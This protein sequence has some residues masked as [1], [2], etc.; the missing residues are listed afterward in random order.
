MNIY[1]KW[2]YPKPVMDMR[3]AIASGQYLEIGDPSFYWPLMWPSKRGLDVNLNILCAGCGSNQAAYYA[4]QHPTWNVV[5]IDVSGSSLAH[6]Q[7]L[8][9]KHGLSNLELIEMDLSRIGELEK[10]FDFITCTGVLHH[11]DAPDEGLR[12]LAGALHPDGVMNLMVYGKSLRMGI[13]P[14]QEAFRLMRMDQSQEDVDLIKT[15][16]QSLP[17]DHAIQRYIH[18]ANDLNFDAG[19]VDTFLNP[20]DRA[21]SVKEIFEFT[22]RS[23]LE[24]LS[25]CEPAEY[26]LQ[27]QIPPHHPV[28][29]KLNDLSS[30]DAAHVC[31]LLLQSRGTHRWLVAHPEYVSM[32]R[33]PFGEDTLFD[34][35]VRLTPGC[36]LDVAAT[37]TAPGSIPYVRGNLRVEMPKDL[38]NLIQQMDGKRSIRSVLSNIDTVANGMG[39]FKR[40]IARELKAL[41]DMGHIQI[42]LHDLNEFNF[43]KG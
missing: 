8:K 11:L 30:E 35:S 41:Y 4:C 38:S 16:L 22:R 42:F 13:Y 24:F 5:G 36:V 33:I 21:Y 26:S 17:Q 39:T 43:S 27:A 3:A 12:A 28:W 31:D 1:H 15:V 25:W 18:H 37:P 23:G 32:N 9:D 34:C 40:E 2:V 10:Q 7:F 14:L 19:L 29:R 6:Q 20:V